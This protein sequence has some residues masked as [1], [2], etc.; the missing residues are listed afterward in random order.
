MCLLLDVSDHSSVVY[1]ENGTSQRW[2]V[3]SRPIEISLAT[4][5]FLVE[6]V[7]TVR[8]RGM[9]SGNRS[10]IPLSLTMSNWQRSFAIQ[11]ERTWTSLFCGSFY[12]LCLVTIC[13][14]SALKNGRF[15]FFKLGLEG[16]IVVNL[17]MLSIE[18]SR[19]VLMSLSEDL[20]CETNATLVFLVFGIDPWVDNE[21]IFYILGVPVRADA[22]HTWAAMCWG[23]MNVWDSGTEAT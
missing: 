17:R 11:D 5:C 13:R 18:V 23:V 14:L 4:R 15:C 12:F 8:W 3:I 19:Y 6:T 1:A 9:S 20:N 7:S 21:P 22:A 2:S 16:N 10:R